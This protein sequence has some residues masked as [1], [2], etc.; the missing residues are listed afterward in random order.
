MNLENVSMRELLGLAIPMGKAARA[1]MIKKSH[2]NLVELRDLDQHIA[3]CEKDLQE[4][5]VLEA[6]STST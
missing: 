4:I 1:S 5:L 3:N 6:G 2:V